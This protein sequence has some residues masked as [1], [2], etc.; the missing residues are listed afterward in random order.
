VA[1]PSVNILML[2]KYL[3]LGTRVRH[4]STSDSRG[5]SGS[6]VELLELLL[7]LLAAAAP[8]PV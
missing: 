6:V 4:F 3:T 1:A 5:R 8:G 2:L 7:L